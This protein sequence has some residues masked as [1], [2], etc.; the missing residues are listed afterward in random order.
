MI[1]KSLLQQYFG[2]SFEDEL[3]EEMAK[4]AQ[5]RSF[6]ENDILMDLDDAI[7]HM[8]L[9]LHGAIR[10][11]RDDDN[12]GELLLYY[13]EK[14]ETCAMTMTCCLGTKTSNIRAAAETAGEMLQIPVQIMDSWLAKYPTWRAFVFNSYQDRLDEMM[15]SIDNL[16]FNDS[17]GR[18]KNYLIESASVNKS[19]IVNKTHAEI[20]Y[21]L[22]TSRVVI[23]RL[24][25]ALENE[26]FI[27][28]QR[29]S[30]SII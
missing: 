12:D 16:A 5:I 7:T 2:S 8:P 21:E 11:M 19:R 29:N 20:A 25:K 28:Q 10:I 18:L 9:L 24:L 3:L 17:K 4:I 14:G 27:M 13:L 30:I 6:K 1:D 22:N 15:R 26:G 23:S